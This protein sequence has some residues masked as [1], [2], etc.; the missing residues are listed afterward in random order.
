MEPLNDDEL[1]RALGEWRAPSAPASLERKVLPREPW[2]KWVMT[3]SIRIPVPVL[4]AVAAAVLAYVAMTRQP[5]PQP[6]RAGTVS[7]AD[8]QPVQDAQPLVFRREQ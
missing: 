8:F 6:V 7:L 1:K 4:V 3:G 2:W 5:P